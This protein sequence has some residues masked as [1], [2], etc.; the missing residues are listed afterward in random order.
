MSQ[1]W[2]AMQKALAH[3]F[4]D[5]TGVPFIWDESL[6]RLPR[7]SIGVLALGQSIAVGRDAHRYTF[8]DSNISLD[9]YGYRELTINVQ[10][11]ARLAKAAPSSR[12]LAEKARLSLANPEY[13]DELRRAGLVFVETHPLLNLDFSRTTR[14][15]LRSSFDVVFRFV[16]HERQCAEH[17]G[18]FDSVTLKEFMQ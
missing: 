12:V 2:D 11:R 10:I 4:N 16:M 14:R 9:M 13:R 8:R 7:S 5:A 1:S 17:I 3:V 15:E 18:F 6:R